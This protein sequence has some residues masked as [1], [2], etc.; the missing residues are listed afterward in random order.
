M[1]TKK[2]KYGLKALVHLSQLP[3]GQLAFV[4][5]IATTNKIPKK[6]LDAILGELR[7][8]G[9]VQSRKGKDGG[10]RLAKPAAEI[11][12]GHVVRVLDGPLAPIPCAS[13][14]QYQPCDDCDEATCQIRHMMLEVRQAIA[15][16]LDNRSLAQVRDAANDDIL[17][18]ALNHA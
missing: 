13:R 15:G 10:Y 2:G 8:A 14:T 6:F 5:D 4:G 12:I 1:L 3:A 16:V 11:K 17:S 18:D 7:N 9:F